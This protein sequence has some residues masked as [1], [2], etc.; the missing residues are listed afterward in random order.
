VTSTDGLN[1]TFQFPNGVLSA[2]V[3]LVLSDGGNDVQRMVNFTI[4]PV[5]DPPEHDIPEQQTARED[6]PW[7]M[8]LSHRVWDVDNGTED[9]FLL[10]DSPYASVDGL[11]LTMLF[12]EP[13]DEYDLWFNISDGINTTQVKL[14]FTI[15]PA[16]TPPGA[17]TYFSVTAGDGLVELE[18]RAPQYDGGS[19]ILGYRV[20]RGLALND[21][22]KIGDVDATTITF[23]DNDLT[24]GV[25][26]Y[27]AVLAYTILGNGVISDIVE[28]RPAG[29]PTVPLDLTA[30]PG[31]E[32]VTL[33]WEAPEKDG[34]LPVTSY[35]VH[36][37]PTDH[38]LMWE[39]TVQGT[40]YTF[41][42]LFNGETYYFAVSARNEMG[43][44]PRSAAIQ[45]IPVSLPEA[46][47][48]LSVTPG[49][50]KVTLTWKPPIDTGGLDIIEFAIY[51][52]GAP[53]SLELLILRPL[54]SIYEDT[55]VDAGETY[56][57][58][59]AAITELGEGPFCAAVSAIPIGP[60]G[61]PR[62]ISAESSD[63]QVTLRWEAPDSDGGS[64]ITSYIILRGDTPDDLVKISQLLSS[65][66]SY[67]DEDVVNGRSYF[68]AVMAI[69][70]VGEGPP[71]GAWEIA[72]IPL[73]TVPGR[74]HM[75]TG[76]VEGGRVELTWLPPSDNGSH[77]IERYRIYR[78]EDPESMEIVAS[79]DPSTSWT[80][81][82]VKRGTTYYYLITAVNWVGQGEP[83]EIEVKV[84]KEKDE[85]PG[86]GMMATITA[87]LAALGLLEK[88]RR[89]T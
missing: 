76:V 61:M 84:P 50:E 38:Q 22:H 8:D 17:P 72:P 12:P 55:E 69:N 45:M 44:G 15:I 18:W 88:G 11:N 6:E 41:T 64:P 70:E 81:E 53:D 32:Q 79:L 77:H 83:S 16:P 86:F 85:G 68:Y 80:D 3:P 13:I 24:N 40:E 2:D 57:Y 36:K 4:Q 14:H 20:F 67:L 42:G 62:N 39:E 82:D 63:E 89:K 59:V 87:T 52:G 31:D 47:R 73:L 37:G 23:T 43:E 71:T 28:A 51:R 56:Y 27:Y 5:N 66:T 78:G 1:V 34:G 60:P 19:S 74:V 7:T 49:T 21:L 48:E 30:E 58:A 10:T 75:F 54:S 65:L 26:Y 29:L 33:T 35:Y 25:T 9:L 46:P